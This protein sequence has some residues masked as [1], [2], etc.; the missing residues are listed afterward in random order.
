MLVFPGGKIGA[1]IAKIFH[2]RV[3]IIIR[4]KISKVAYMPTL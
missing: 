3:I 1:E 4:E 2:L